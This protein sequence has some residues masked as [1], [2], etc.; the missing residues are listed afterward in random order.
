MPLARIDISKNASDQLVRIVSDA[1]YRAMVEVANVPAHDKFQIINRHA[2]DE[3]IYPQEGYLGVQYTAGLILIQVTWVAGRSTDIKK[4]FYRQI[5]DEIH[6]KG[7]V[8]KQDV[9]INLVD[10]SRE[11]WSFGNGEMQ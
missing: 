2:P 6:E 5:A 10:S 1:V 7:G 4:K 9:W 8:R 3:I 11:D